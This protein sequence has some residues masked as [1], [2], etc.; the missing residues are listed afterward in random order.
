MYKS[1]VADGDKYRKDFID[2]IMSYVNRKNKEGFENRESFMPP[3]TFG[4]KI[5]EYRKQYVEMLGINNFDFEDCP[6]PEMSFL[7]EDSDCKIYRVVV[8]ITKE[9]P[10]SGLLMIP[11]GILK[12][13]L[14]IAQHGG[15]GTPELCS[16]MNGKNNYNRIVRRLLQKGVVVFAPQLLLWNC[17][18]EIDTQPI[19]NIVYNRRIV[20][21]ELKRFGA[22]ITALEI[23]GIMNSIT[24]LSGLECVESD[25][26]GMT[27]IS[28]GGYFTLHT[29]AADVRI[30]AGYS[31]ACFN[32]RNKYSWFDWCY[33]N[34]CNM[35]HDAEVAALCAPRKLYV[36]VGKE[37]VVFDYKTAICEAERVEKYYS[38]LGCADNYQFVAWQGA[39][40][41]ASTDE[42]FD[43]MFSAFK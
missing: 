39:H 30:K 19:H 22:S 29:M 4:D 9:V 42:G 31:N 13:P 5:E 43:F 17:E 32:D 38:A 14:V 8:Y 6:E 37:D 23:K 12:A 27:G 11:H 36:A 24:Y 10:F 33:K 7:G 16:D 25:K 20:D 21:N 28:Y 26:I 35:F 2:G 18:E 41:V 34:S 40:T 1:I 15:G 3:E